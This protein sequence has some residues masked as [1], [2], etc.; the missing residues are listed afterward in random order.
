MRPVV[1]TDKHYVQVSVTSVGLGA[2]LATV[3]ANAVQDATSSAT[4]VREGAKISAVFIEMWI[5][6]D[7]AA[8][9]SVSVS[10]EKRTGNSPTMTFAQSQALYSF[11]NKKNIMYH[12]QGL[13]SPNVQSGIPFIR[14][15]FKIPKSKQRFG[16]G[17][18]LTL[19]VSGITN[20]AVI[21]GFFTYK[22]QF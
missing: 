8:Q 13:T 22:E 10:V 18:N 15:W 5:T 7:D 11:P 20:G 17:D 1:N 12:T 4:E 9:G 16:L 14:Q 6:S 19:N 2:L 21:C 3:F